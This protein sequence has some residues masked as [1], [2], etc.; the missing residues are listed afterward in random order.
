[1]LHKNFKF[2][3]PYKCTYI[4]IYKNI[5]HTSDV[6]SHMEKPGKTSVKPVV[7]NVCFPAGLSPSHMKC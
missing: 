7:N 1:M 2:N 6:Q 5:K 4:Y 3:I